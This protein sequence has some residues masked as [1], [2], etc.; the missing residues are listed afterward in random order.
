M[1]LRVCV[2][3]DFC[4]P[5][6]VRN[7]PL[8]CILAGSVA[9]Q[10]VYIPCEQ[11]Q[12]M[13]EWSLHPKDQ[14]DEIGCLTNHLQLWYGKRGLTE[15][16][17]REFKE[18]VRMHLKKRNPAEKTE[19]LLDNSMGNPDIAGMADQILGSESV[20]IVTV[21]PPMSQFGYVTISLYIDDKGGDSRT[22]AHTYLHRHTHTFHTQTC[23]YLSIHIYMTYM[24]TFISKHTPHLKPQWRA[25]CPIITA[26]P[27]CWK[28]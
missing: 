8:S 28:Q 22:T 25:T 2:S 4:V 21:L 7:Q 15:E 18:H 16:Q 9:F 19:E 3:A 14:E 10:F 24:H 26:R 5:V 12:P 11:G 1:C 17:K 23:M 13:E 6:V 20:E 27:R